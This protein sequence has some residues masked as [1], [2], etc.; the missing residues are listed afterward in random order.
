[1]IMKLEF[2]IEENEAW[3]MAQFLKRTTFADYLQYTE[4]SDKEEQK[5]QARVMIAGIEKLRA[6]LAEAGFGPR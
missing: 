5:A 4:G 2:E 1:M 3:E 6:S